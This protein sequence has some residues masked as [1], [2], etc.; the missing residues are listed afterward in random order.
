MTDDNAES[1]RKS[2]SEKAQR[3]RLNFGDDTLDGGFAQIPNN[4]LR[5]YHRLGITA[6]EAMFIVHLIGSWYDFL[7]N[8]PNLRRIAQR[9]SKHLRTIQR[10]SSSLEMDR[11]AIEVREQYDDF[12]GAQIENDYNLAPLIQAVNAI[13]REE[14]KAAEAAAAEKQERLNREHGRSPQMRLP[15]GDEDKNPPPEEPKPTPPEPP[16]AASTATFLQELGIT[17][18]TLSQIADRD[19]A[20]AQA[21]WWYIQ[22]QPGL[23]NKNL[24]ID[25]LIKRLRENDAPP[26]G[27]L[28]L[29][30][31][32]L[33]LSNDQRWTL[34]EAEKNHRL[35][36]QHWRLPDDFPP[37]DEAATTALTELVKADVEFGVTRPEPERIICPGCDQ[38]FW[39]HDL[40]QDCDRCPDCCTCEPV[41]EDPALTEA[42][43]IWRE[44]ITTLEWR[45][46][47]GVINQWI[48]PIQVLGLEDGELQL[49][50][51]NGR[52]KE[53]LEKG[54]NRAGL[55]DQA[56][57]DAAGR[58]L[59]AKF[60]VPTADD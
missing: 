30:R 37:L 33:Q 21:W 3:F 27:Y 58:P 19:E 41:V 53:Q 52:T 2:Q 13:Y 43:A 60:I 39:P 29:A 59:K 4:F 9:M 20:I 15:L 45:V 50:A 11:K 31:V 6:E 56:I 8:D 28:E 1:K 17:E 16:L 5:Y 26:P 48:R 44:A 57:S 7:D 32:W 38:T 14:K 54:I 22:T 49:S 12:S 10:Y 18:P 24:E 34:L 35:Y 40:C 25:Y 47:R 51:D 55:I 36:R 42:K 23:K 46:E